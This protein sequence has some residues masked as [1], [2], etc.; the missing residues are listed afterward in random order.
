MCTSVAILAQALSL[1]VAAMQRQVL[2]PFLPTYGNRRLLAPTLPLTTCPALPLQRELAINNLLL[3]TDT[4]TDGNC[5][6]DAFAISLYDVATVSVFIKPRNG[7][8]KS[9]YHLLGYRNPVE[10]DT[11]RKKDS[12]TSSMPLPFSV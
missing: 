2:D 4:S 9:C 10:F 8:E 11:F 6:I 5:G 12:F 3:R 1:L 7:R